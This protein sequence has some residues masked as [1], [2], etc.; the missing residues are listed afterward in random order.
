MSDV[1]ILCERHIIKPTSP[2][3]SECDNLS[4]LAKNLYNS[5]LY[6]QRQSLFDSDFQNYY[7]VNR[8]FTH[9]NQPDYRA[10]PAKVSKQVQML[11]DKNFKSY[12]A[13]VK[14]KTTE[15]Y[16]PKVKPPKYLDKTVGRCTVPYP[17]DALSLKVEGYV[18]L[19]KTS[20]AV[21]TNIP[22][23][24]IQGARI[25]PKGNHYVIEILYKVVSKPLRSDLPKRVAFIDPGLNN[26]VT[27]TSNCFNPILINGRPLKAINQ[28]ANKE[29]AN[30]K[31][32]L[33]VHGLYTSPLLQSVYSKRTRRITDMLH[34]VTTQLVNHLDSYNIDTIIFG[35]NI[36]Q[37][38]DIN[39]GKVT[40]QNFVQIPFTQLI[41]QLQ[42]KCQLKG[43]RFIVTEESH[44][45]KCSFLDKE[46]AEH[47][48]KYKGKRVKRGLFKTSKGILVNADVNGSLNI[49]CKYLTKLGL[50][51]D[52][53]HQTL[54]QFMVNPKLVQLI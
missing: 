15:G 9:T 28:L 31:S 12:F 33:I 25:V 52:E 14:K 8:E 10:L 36:G 6:Y 37:K 2:L 44:T 26:L 24:D 19:S 22:K 48:D 45:S 40:N 42:Y 13:L 41:A 11:V 21:K 7:A 30:L 49:G 23:E 3:F 51:T 5:T 20:I 1:L 29:I 43:I 16:S 46:S 50:Y 35:H 27:V 34:K 32:K 4:F 18:N 54:I 38:Q 39:L 53:L 47:H 17:K